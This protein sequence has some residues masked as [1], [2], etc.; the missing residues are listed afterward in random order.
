MSVVLHVPS[1]PYGV[2]CQAHHW[3]DEMRLE[4]NLAEH[5]P[6]ELMAHIYYPTAPSSKQMYQ[7]YD[8]NALQS[9]KEFVQAKS[10]APLWL[11]GGW[12]HLRWSWCIFRSSPDTAQHLA[13]TPA[14]A[15]L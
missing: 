7:A 3:V 9:S 15:V 6:R 13:H 2:G 8:G 5:T 10:G 12:D 11:L 4:Q 1:G 14:C